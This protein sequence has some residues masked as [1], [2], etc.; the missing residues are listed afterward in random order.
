MTTEQAAHIEAHQWKI[1]NCAVHEWQTAHNAFLAGAAYQQKQ[2][3]G[4][5]KELVE[6]LREITSAEW[7]VTHDWGGDRDAVLDKAR[8]LINKYSTHG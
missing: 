7:M 6:G 8:Q 5:I 4:A 2:D 3:K 1:K